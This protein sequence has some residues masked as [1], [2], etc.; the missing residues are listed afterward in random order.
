MS[1]HEPTPSRRPDPGQTTSAEDFAGLAEVEDAKLA[2]GGRSYSQGQ[3]VRRRFLAHKPAVISSI[4]LLTVVV[5]AFSSIGFSGQGGWW[6]RDFTSTGLVQDQGRPTLFAGQLFGEHPFGQDATGR[7]YFARVMRG[8]QQSLIVAVGV[9]LVSTIVGVLVGAIAG[10]FR[11][12][13]EAVLMRMT[14][15]VIVVPLLAL[16]AVF[17]QFAQQLPGG[18][19]TLAAAIGLAT[20]TGMARLVRAEVLSLR[21]KEYVSAAISMGASPVRIIGKHMLPNSIGVIIVNATF[22]I[23][24]AIL[25][26]TSL[27]YL[28]FGVQS[29]EVS[30]GSLIQN[31]QNAFTTRPWLFWFSGLF[32]I[33]IALTVNF[34]GDGL[35]D[36]IDPRQQR[37]GA[38]RPGLLA[39]M[40]LRGAGKNERR[41][42]QARRAEQAAGTDH[43]VHGPAGRPADPTSGRT[44]ED[45]R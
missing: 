21:E 4:I 26:E 39:A 37:S 8:T 15:V 34:I 31:N 45:G 32:I 43:A 44:E 19:F 11:G 9:A 35:R 18:T 27:S 12:W 1:H 10:Y 14:D 6:G 25:L 22:S 42:R 29:P 24:T 16:A 40:G 13:V 38:R 30:L 17:G 20:W 41:R 2:A 28:G 3:L 23:A 33:V 5:L 7:D 36:A